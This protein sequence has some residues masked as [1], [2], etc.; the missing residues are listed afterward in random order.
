MRSGRSLRAAFAGLTCAGLAGCGASARAFDDT[1]RFYVPIVDVRGQV[2]ALADC[3][4]PLKR[5]GI[6][7]PARQISAAGVNKIVLAVPAADGGQP[8]ELHFTLEDLG[9]GDGQR[10]ALRLHLALP[11]AAHE[12]DLGPGQLITPA[13]FAKQLMEQLDAYFAL[14]SGYRT[15]RPID[16]RADIVRHCQTI[17][18][19]LDGGAVL[20][21]SRLQAELHRQHRREALNWLFKDNYRLSNA[22]TSDYGDGDG[23]GDF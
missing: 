16:R 3:P 4:S 17:G 23:D 10:T 8:I 20:I 11:A 15:A 12:L 2:L 18:R 9:P 14:Q 7:V 22:S 5:L 13:G 6:A 1:Y 19:L 21:S